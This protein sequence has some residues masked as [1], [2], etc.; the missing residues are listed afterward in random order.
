MAASSSAAHTGLFGQI[1][2]KLTCTNYILWWTQIT[3]QLHGAGF[4]CYVDG[5]MPEPAKLVVTN[6]KDGKEEASPNPLHP[7]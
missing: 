4:F 6:D 2:E 5:S 1:T 3:P 7:I